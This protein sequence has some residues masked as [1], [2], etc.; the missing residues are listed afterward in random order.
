MPNYF[1]ENP[2]IQYHFNKLDIKEIVEI[3]EDN[4][5]QSIT[6]NYA[7]VNYED[8]VENYKKVLEVIGDIA[9]NFIAPRSTGVDEEG[10]QFTE[11][12]VTYAKGTQ[13]NLEML[14]KA[15]LMGAILPREYGGLNFPFTIYSMATEIVSRADASLMNIFGLQDIAEMIRKFGNES[16]KNKYL[17]GFSSGNY[18]GAM[19]L[20]E[21]D[22]GSDLQAVKL[23]AYQN[24]EGK[25]FLR[26][27]KRFITNGNAEVLLVL[28]RSEAGTKDGR[29]LSMF[30]CM[31][32]DT[33][34]VRRIENKLGIH[35]SPTCELQFND[36]PA[37]LVGSRKFGL[38]KYVF[39]LMYR[40]RVGVSAQALGISESAYEV[41][42]KYAKEREQFGK[43]IYNIP[44]VSNMLIDMRVMIES[45]RTLFYNTTYYVDLKEALEQKI[46]KL[47]GKGKSFT[48]EN[49]RLK[50]VT[51]IV[52]FLTPLT[53]YF[54]TESSNKITY[55][56][57]QI[58]G[59]TGYMR[60][61]K[62]EQLARDAR[63]TNIYEGTS[64]MQVV[65]AISGVLN[66]VFKEY[67][68]KK[69]TKE[70]TGGLSKLSNILKEIREIFYDA[71]K[72]VTEKKD[73]AFQDIAAKDLVEIYGNL[74]TGYLLLDEAENDQR[75]IFVANRFIVGALSLTKKNFE[76]IKNELFS[77]IMH[78]DK[79]L[80]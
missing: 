10:A 51:K 56:S 80:L 18:T 43:S 68:N 73:T 4:Y 19:A 65:A 39:E 74:Y 75:K 62:V 46:E 64:Q 11:G 14:S 29:G 55:D 52:N 72:Y 47:K 67:F 53:K 31:G 63:I 61:F 27:V 8:A 69:E 1:T 42:L 7:P 2:D 22:A 60:E 3:I 40:A 71:L 66:D 23:H 30:V 44:V 21:P 20:T 28:A 57:L 17:P 24:D 5:E 76:N 45:N 50:Q 15:D 12:K 48:D 58:H 38:I 33:V 78:T 70:Y 54:I 37:E 77:D 25:W 6:Y 59:G 34:I 41:A 16:Q 13:E 9:G 79:I 36:T 49:L 35:G 26:G 32:D